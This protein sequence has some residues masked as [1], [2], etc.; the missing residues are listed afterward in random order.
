MSI[1]VRIIET[2]D[3]RREWTHTALTSD[4][5]RAIA[6]AVERHFGAKA[7]FMQD[8]G[9]PRSAFGNIGQIWEN[10]PSSGTSCANALTNRVRI[11]TE[12]A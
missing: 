1:H 3:R 9:L 11:I 12:A 5:R 8:N 2:G 7:Y 6:R 4:H 10:V